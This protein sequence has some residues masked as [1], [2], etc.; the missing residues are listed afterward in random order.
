L[1]PAE[2]VLTSDSNFHGL[3]GAGITDHVVLNSPHDYYYVPALASVLDVRN[4]NAGNLL[5]HESCP[6]SL[7]ESK[8]SVHFKYGTE[9]YLSLPPT[10]IPE[11]GILEISQWQNPLSPD[12]RNLR[13]DKHVKLEFSSRSHPWVVTK[14]ITGGAYELVVL[15][16]DESGTSWT[17]STTSLGVDLMATE[18]PLR[19]DS[20]AG[21]MGVEIV[22]HDRFF[23]EADIHEGFAWEDGHCPVEVVEVLAAQVCRLAVIR[24]VPMTMAIFGPTVAGARQGAAPGVPV[25]TTAQP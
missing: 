4:V 16:Q 15:E 8:V 22:L 19:F 5:S 3:D 24:W 18:T 6:F 17:K 23:D 20:G 21:D 12:G 10:V 9:S 25:R 1:T 2:L 7:T 11:N 14:E 13:P